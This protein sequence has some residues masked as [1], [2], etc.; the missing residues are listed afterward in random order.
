MGGNTMIAKRY[1][2]LLTKRDV[3]TLFKRLCGILGSKKAACEAT[4]IERKTTY[5]WKDVKD[6][7]IENKV[8][9]LS[10]SLEVEPVE[11]LE[12]LSEKSL[13]RTGKLL[14]LTLSTIYDKIMFSKDKNEVN[15]LSNKFFKVMNKFDKPVTKLIEQEISDMVVE[16][17][18]KSDL[19]PQNKPLIMYA[20]SFEGAESTTWRHNWYLVNEKEEEPDKR[21]MEQWS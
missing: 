8:K 10:K 7:T 1:A 2:E 21:V 9:V 14:Y 18:K 16:I 17:S 5:N 12:F 19:A 13:N 20:F 11:T 15:D 6:I 3:I 4:G